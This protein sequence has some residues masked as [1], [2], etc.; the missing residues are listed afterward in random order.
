M[1]K[2]LLNLPTPPKDLKEWYEWATRLDNNYRKMQHIFNR[3]PRDNTKNEPKKH[4][5]FQR[6][7][8]DPNTMD[9]DALTIEKRTEMMKK[10]QCFGCGE[11]GH[12]NRDCLKKKR[13][14]TPTAPKKMSGKELYTHI[15]SFTAT[16]EEK[17]M[18]EFYQEAE[19][20]GF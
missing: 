9:I 16:M 7:E 13:T 8:R 11:S 3:T 1:Q 12:L 14:I 10:G 6:K 5:Q 15:R 17:D 18:D 2:N 4:W 20:G 19:K